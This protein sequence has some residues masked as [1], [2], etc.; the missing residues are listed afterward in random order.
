M[1]FVGVCQPSLA[2][3]YTPRKL[4]MFRCV[5]KKCLAMSD[6]TKINDTWN[7]Y[8][9]WEGYSFQRWVSSISPFPFY[10]PGTRLAPFS[11]STWP[12]QSLL[13]YWSQ[14]NLWQNLSFFWSKILPGIGA[15]TS[16]DA[17]LWAR[18]LGLSNS[19][20]ENLSLMWGSKPWKANSAN[21]L[22]Q[23][24]KL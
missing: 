14:K 24:D 13:P 22:S 21:W 23:R 18:W 17:T 3:K 6:L 15:R 9:W 4:Q 12:S 20:E 7:Q 19:C 16:M 8:I 5:I 11:W 2:P 10:Q 1:P